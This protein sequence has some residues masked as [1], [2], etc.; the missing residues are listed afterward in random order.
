MHPEHS[1]N[2]FGEPEE[3][4]LKSTV[5]FRGVGVIEEVVDE[6]ELDEEFDEVVVGEDASPC[7]S[8]SSSR[9]VSLSNFM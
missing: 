1:E 2:G 6:G 8:V 5:G 7:G 3:V 4:E 9:Y